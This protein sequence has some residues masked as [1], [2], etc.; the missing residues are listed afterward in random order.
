[1]RRDPPH[2][3]PCTPLAAEP[4]SGGGGDRAP[5]SEPASFWSEPASFCPEQPRP[6]PPTPD[7]GFPTPNPPRQGAAKPAPARGSRTCPAPPPPPG[8]GGSAGPVWPCTAPAEPPSLPPR[9]T[10]VPSAA[11]YFWPEQS[12]PRRDPGDPNAATGK[13]Q[14]RDPPEWG[15]TPPKAP[16][17]PVQQKRSRGTAP[18]PGGVWTREGGHG[19]RP[20]VPA[21][22]TSPIPAEGA[23]ET[24]VE[25]PSDP[26]TAPIQP[27]LRL[28]PAGGAPAGLF[29]SGP[30]FMAVYPAPGAAAGTRRPP[31]GGPPAPGTPGEGTGH[32]AAAAGQN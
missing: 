29:L 23:A 11:L 17:S 16:P 27:N 31:P 2:T 10:I 12:R 4:P 13:G 26:G 21:G 25:R 3:P 8:T 14:R 19:G 6:D 30:G 1:M 22:G 28:A 5:R 20:Q 9:D 24:G 15:Q 18:A 7:R 32:G